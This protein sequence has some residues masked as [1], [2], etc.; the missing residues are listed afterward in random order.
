MSTAAESPPSTSPAAPAGGSD[1][2][3]SSASSP[4]PA[5]VAE[6]AQAY[7]VPDAGDVAVLGCLTAGG[8]LLRCKEALV[9]GPRVLSNLMDPGAFAPAPESCT[10][11]HSTPGSA[12]GA[13]S[14]PD[15]LGNRYAGSVPN[16]ASNSNVLPINSGSGSSNCH[17][18]DVLLSRAVVILDGPLHVGENTACLVLPPHTPGCGNPHP[19]RGL[20]LAPSLFVTPPGRFLLHLSTPS[21][22]RSS[23]PHARLDLERAVQKLAECGGLLGPS[24]EASEAQVSDQ[25]R[26]GS[27]QKA[28]EAHGFGQTLET[29]DRSKPRA[30][31]VHYYLQQLTMPAGLDGN[32][33]A[34]AGARA[35]NAAAA[36]AVAPATP[37]LKPYL[38]SG[39]VCCPGP[40]PS[41]AGCTAAV[42]AAQ[43]LLA[44]YFPAVPWLGEHST[45]GPEDGE[46]A[47]RE[48]GAGLQE[49]DEETEAIMALQASVDQLKALEQKDKAQE[50]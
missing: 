7:P 45:G 14:S 29:A 28:S 43:H 34:T 44:Q 47:S 49:P 41:M 5:H 24:Q 50:M 32:G 4:A 35:F 2:D 3:S 48:G 38:P 10:A 27:S 25:R 20:L 8:Q 16:H 22:R 6:N 9:A 37:A 36:A 46:E 42:E 13:S 23:G 30:L 40:N 11:P 18:C 31:Q 33:T 39:V 1:A 21:A 12:S 19:I 17:S 15:N 26:Q